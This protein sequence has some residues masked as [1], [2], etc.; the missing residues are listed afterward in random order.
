MEPLALAMAS[1]WTKGGPRKGGEDDREA[2]GKEASM[3]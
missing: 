1:N 2:E 3:T